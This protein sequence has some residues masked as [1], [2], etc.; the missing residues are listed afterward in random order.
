MPAA[1]GLLLGAAWGPPLLLGSAWGRTVLNRQHCHARAQELG[2]TFETGPI[3][4]DMQ[5]QAEEWRE[6]LVEAAVEVEDEAME[7]YL[8]GEV[9]A[10]PKSKSF[11][12][13]QLWPL[14]VAPGRAC[15]HTCEGTTGMVGCVKGGAC[16]QGERHLGR[17]DSTSCMTHNQ[18]PC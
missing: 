2:A 6:K 8:E 17:I 1:L 18:V 3:P 12:F 9:R 14:A 11:R 5:A 10:G 7:A 4:D 15:L 16:L 13:H